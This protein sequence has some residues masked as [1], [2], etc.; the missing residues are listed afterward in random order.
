MCVILTEETGSCQN[1]FGKHEVV[2]VKCG[3]RDCSELNNREGMNV[4]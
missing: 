2:Y 4:V 1:E 3:K